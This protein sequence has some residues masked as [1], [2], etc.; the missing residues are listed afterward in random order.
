MLYKL[1]VIIQVGILPLRRCIE[2]SGLDFSDPCDPH[3]WQVDRGVLSPPL[4]RLL[5]VFPLGLTQYLG[6]LALRRLCWPIN[7]STRC[8]RDGAAQPPAS[9]IKPRS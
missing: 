5:A 1:T 9:Q 4:I 6:K 7:V 3:T 2:L 8:N